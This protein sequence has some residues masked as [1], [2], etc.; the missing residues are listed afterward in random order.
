MNK[1]ATPDEARDSRQPESEGRVVLQ[2]LVMRLRLQLA[3]L[4]SRAD[5]VCAHR[6]GPS[7]PVGT[8]K[9]AIQDLAMEAQKARE[10]LIETQMP[11]DAGWACN[12]CGTVY[13]TE[14]EA[15]GCPCPM[16]SH[17]RTKVSPPTL[18]AF[19]QQEP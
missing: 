5:Y 13:D 7:D 16:H 17:A 8:R 2:R 19:E 11:E 4:V 1:P 15:A 14:A 9:V 6:Y 10:L 12:A 18:T 3:H